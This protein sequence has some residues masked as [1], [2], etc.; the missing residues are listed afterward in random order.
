MN[1]ALCI[2]KYML[3]ETLDYWRKAKHH[4]VIFTCR[5][6]CISSNMRMKNVLPLPEYFN[7]VDTETTLKMI[8][9]SR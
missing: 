5:I 1:L 7:L 3:S 2:S 8:E 6:E 9:R 4:V